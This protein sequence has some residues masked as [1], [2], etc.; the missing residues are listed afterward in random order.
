[1]GLA[2]IG[3]CAQIIDGALGIYARALNDGVQTYLT[4][5]PSQLVYRRF[6]SAAANAGQLGAVG[7][8]PD[9][10]QLRIPVQYLANLL[11][12]G[13]TWPVER[14]LDRFSDRWRRP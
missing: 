3:F 12:A 5:R 13:D 7:E 6:I 11:T 1:M 9:V 2:A 4:G 8:L 10:K 14:A